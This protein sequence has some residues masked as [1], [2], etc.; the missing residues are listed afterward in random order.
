MKTAIDQA[1]GTW[2]RTSWFWAL[3]AL[4]SFAVGLAVPLA[5]ALV[6]MACATVSIMV[7]VYGPALAD[8]LKLP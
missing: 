4:F 5:G 8:W 1:L 3:H 7:A 6:C 2:L